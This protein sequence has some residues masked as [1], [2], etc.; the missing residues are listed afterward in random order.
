[1]LQVS[2]HP[3][4]VTQTAG[5]NNLLYSTAGLAK[6]FEDVSKFSSLSRAYWKFEEHNK[7]LETSIIIILCIV[8]RQSVPVTGPV[9]PR[10][11]VEL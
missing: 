10:G 2:L 8:K 11:W 1:V 7:A 4:D 5:C 9:W 3:C 6:L